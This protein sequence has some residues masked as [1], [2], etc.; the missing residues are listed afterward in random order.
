MTINCI[1]MGERKRWAGRKFTDLRPEVKTP[2]ERKM[3]KAGGIGGIQ[4]FRGYFADFYRGCLAP[5]GCRPVRSGPSFVSADRLK[6]L[7]VQRQHR[8][9]RHA[10]EGGRSGGQRSAR[11]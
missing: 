2:R 8:G 4:E 9:A 10:D 11:S 6:E 1:E 7:H 3:T 5:R